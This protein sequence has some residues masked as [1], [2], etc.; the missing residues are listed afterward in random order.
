MA[1]ST[2]ICKICGTEYEYSYYP[3]NNDDL[4]RYQDIA[5]SPEHGAEYFAK[6]IVARGEEEDPNGGGVENDPTGDSPEESYVRVALEALNQFID[7]HEFAS[8]EVGTPE[9][10]IEYLNESQE[11]EEDDG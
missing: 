6:V 8:W 7:T 4:Y 1:T 11:D 3:R 5:C 9:E 10:F 2:R